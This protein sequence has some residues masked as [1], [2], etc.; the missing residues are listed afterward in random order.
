MSSKHTKKMVLVLKCPPGADAM[1]SYLKM[2]ML[3]WTKMQ[4]EYWNLGLLFSYLQNDNE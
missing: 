3:V 4:A 2:L 1:E